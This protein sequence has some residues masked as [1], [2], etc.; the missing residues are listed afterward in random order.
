VDVIDFQTLFD[1]GL[2]LIGQNFE[3]ELDL[4]DNATALSNV[5]KVIGELKVNYF[6]IF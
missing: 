6:L 3:I 4:P 2:D 5:L 1:Y